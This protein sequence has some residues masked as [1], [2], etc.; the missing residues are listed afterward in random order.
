MAYDGPPEKSLKKG[1]RPELTGA[2]FD[3]ALGEAD[4]TGRGTAAPSDWGS[5]VANLSVSDTPRDPEWRVH[6][7]THL[8]FAVDYRIDPKA[9]ESIF[10]WDSYFFVPESLR[11]HDHTYE[12]N[13]IYE[14]LQ[15]YVRLAVPVVPL[16]SLVGKELQTLRKAIEGNPVEVIALRELRFYACLVRA[17]SLSW[18]TQA[19]AHLDGTPEGLVE[20][21]ES[22]LKLARTCAEITRAMRLA[23]AIVPQDGTPVAVATQWVDEDISR[24]IETLL[25]ML[26]I[27]LR[28]A[29]ALETT[30]ATVAAVAV[31]EARYRK[32][33]GLEGVGSANADERSIE[34]LEF[35]R[36]VLKRF[37]SS[38][39]WLSFE[40]RD[41]AG[42]VL[43]GLYA[44]AA[45][46][47][48][49]FG[50]LAGVLSPA[51][52]AGGGFTRNFWVG[53]VLVVLAY[54]IRD[55]MKGILQQKFSKVV[56]RHFPDRKWFIHDRERKM[57][58]GG[59]EERSG[60]VHFADIP[61]E[62]LD[63]RRMTRVH[64]FEEEARPERVLW[65][66]KTVTVHGLD[67]QKS[68]TRFTA[69]TEI[70][71][72]NVHRWLEHTDDPKRKIVFADPNDRRIYTAT[73]PRAYNIAVVYRLRKKGDPTA[74]WH[75]NRVVVTRK[76]ILRIDPIC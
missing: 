74:V 66:H 42:W 50:V 32:E 2:P 60:F 28:T 64:A 45:A 9:E 75:R 53:S 17:S 72:L 73:A 56:A 27:D 36:H 71:R 5:L 55:R 22:A 44:M 39:L 62:A 35:R 33:K 41:G 47:A 14:D 46:F 4:E 23:L 54:A 57:K 40:V 61:L 63:M 38:V 8:E 26:A 16:D 24:A 7:R 10:E 6:D 43:E 20:A 58:L 37:T 12:K 48:M 59:V 15:S 34:R 69:L 76:G 25:G 21:S 51:P 52:T 70:F 65:H 18:R 67:L 1:P 3:E 11:L 19:M 30:A 49:I 31:E 68:D 29:G 13:D